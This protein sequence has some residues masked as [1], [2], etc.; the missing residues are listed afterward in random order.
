MS[1]R[2]VW[3]DSVRATACLMVVALHVSA[4]VVLGPVDALGW[5]FANLVDSFT[6]VCVPLFFMTSGFLFFRQRHPR[7][8]NFLRLV[9]ALAFY[10]VLALIA[11]AALG[12]SVDLTGWIYL[13]PAYYHLWFFYPLLVIYAVAVLLEIRPKTEGAMLVAVLALLVVF[14]PTLPT[15]WGGEVTKNAFLLSGGIVH[16]ALYGVAGAVIGSM[17]TSGRLSMH[18]GILMLIYLVASGLIMVR[19]GA[20]SD[21]A[22]E[23][24][25]TFYGY[26][27]VYVAIGALALFS[28]L[29]RIDIGHPLARGFARFVAEHSLVIYGVHALVLD[30]VKQAMKDAVGTS[31]MYFLVTFFTV[32]TV[33]IVISLVIRRLDRFRLLS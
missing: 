7:A 6:R 13:R 24:I 21:L 33:S 23:F 1:E 2:M 22:D 4:Q 19:T 15:V 26:G 9:T 30:G 12:H 18:P 28:A 5:E 29:A 10:S 14:N 25:S 27:H 11:S 8:K 3:L 17:I 32:I 16:Y 31:V 20:A